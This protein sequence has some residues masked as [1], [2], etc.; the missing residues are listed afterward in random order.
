ME[1]YKTMALFSDIVGDK[2]IRVV[3][4]YDQGGQNKIF[5]GKMTIE[6][7][8]ISKS[9]DVILKTAQIDKNKRF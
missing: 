8:F 6:G 1:K 2:T 9:D 4:F 5:K 3:S 7:T